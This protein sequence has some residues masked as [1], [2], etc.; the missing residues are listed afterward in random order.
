M[1]SLNEPV[2]NL[3]FLRNFTGNDPVKIKK[4]V[5]MFL[6]RAPEQLREM[7]THLGTQDWEEVKIIA[8]SL[9][10]QMGYMGIKS[11]EQDLRTI[12]DY[13]G[14]KTRLEQLPALI[15]HL[16]VVLQKAF[17]ELKKEI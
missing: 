12:E 2:I 5:G 16:E 17:E 3:D 8:H 14:N 1:S 15:Q 4:Y 6:D 13:A 11:L 9:K 10:P 7:K